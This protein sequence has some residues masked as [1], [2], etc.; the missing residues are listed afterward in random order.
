MGMPS[1][2]PPPGVPDWVL[3]FGDM[4]SLLLCFFILLFAFSEPKN[5]KKRDQLVESILEKFGTAEALKQ[6]L[7]KSLTKGGTGPVGRHRKDSGQGDGLAGNKNRVQTI[8]LEGRTAIGGKFVFT[9]K[10]ASCLKLTRM[11]SAKSHDR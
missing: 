11:N 6:F 8:A 4:M 5:D 1:E 3:T 2:D 7:D 9:G 10:E